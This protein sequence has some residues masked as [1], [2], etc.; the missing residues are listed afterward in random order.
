MS[1]KPAAKTASKSTARPSRK[2][3]LW[4]DDD[5]FSCTSYKEELETLCRIDVANSP[6]QM[7]KL[8][9]ENGS[10]YYV[11]I[12][13]DIL[14]PFKGLDPSKVEEGLRT[15]LTLLGILRA[16][17]SEFA[18]ISV[19]IFTIRENEDVDRVGREYGVPV[20]RKSEVRMGEFI[21][22]AR[23]RFGL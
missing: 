9:K 8:L 21:D 5:L 20:F 2:R 14:L 7:W 4:V 13:L 22:A 16:P 1:S 11:G 3:V 12:I 18:G 6:E 19:I 10:D 23:E 15:G 17:Q